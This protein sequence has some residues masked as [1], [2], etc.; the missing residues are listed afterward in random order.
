[1]I[2]SFDALGQT[3]DTEKLLLLPCVYDY[4]YDSTGSLE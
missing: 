3:R 2:D 4:V 1:M